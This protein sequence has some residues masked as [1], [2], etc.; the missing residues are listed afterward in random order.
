MKV[1]QCPG[2]AKHESTS[3]SIPLRVEAVLEEIKI[4]G[5]EIFT[6][7]DK[8]ISI[9]TNFKWNIVHEFTNGMNCKETPSYLKILEYIN[10]AL[11]E[12]ERK[13]ADFL[14]NSTTYLYNNLIDNLNT[15]FDSPMEIYGRLISATNK[16]SNSSIVLL[17]IFSWNDI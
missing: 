4:G 17:L 8:Y 12:S 7:I 10:K 9:V 13:I 15:Y 11:K 1:K 6:R 14:D 3:S 16:L 5:H 2:K